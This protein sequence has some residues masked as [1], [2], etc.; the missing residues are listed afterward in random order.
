M[1][2]TNEN[3][4]RAQQDFLDMA[5]WCGQIHETHESFDD[6]IGWVEAKWLEELK[7]LE[8]KVKKEL[9]ECGARCYDDKNWGSM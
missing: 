1:Y 2:L 3:R 5:E 6:E 7:A 9:W 4:S 8:I